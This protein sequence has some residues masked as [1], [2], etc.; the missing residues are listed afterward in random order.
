MPCGSAVCPPPERL[1]HAAAISPPVLD[2]FGRAAREFS[3]DGT[4]YQS[5]VLVSG[6]SFPLSPFDSD[7]RIAVSSRFLG[8]GHFDLLS[9]LFFP[10]TRVVAPFG[11]PR[12]YCSTVCLFPL[13][14]RTYPNMISPS[15]ATA[16]LLRGAPFDNRCMFFCA[17]SHLLFCPPILSF[18]H[19][20]CFLLSLSCLGPIR[21]DLP[22]SFL[23][24][25]TSIPQRVFFPVGLAAVPVHK[26]RGVPELGPEFWL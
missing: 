15:A 12:S 25:G 26:R 17:L 11:C 14:L 6:Q 18:L 21:Q 8:R 5:V 1:P 24:G 20:C 9:L 7:S 13:S 2:F 16:V 3:F 19:H 10:G 23:S 22:Q 4:L